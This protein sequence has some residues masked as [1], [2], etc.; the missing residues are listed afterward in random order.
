MREKKNQNQSKNLNAI[1]DY[2]LHNIFKTILF[3]KTTPTFT[4]EG[5]IVCSENSGVEKSYF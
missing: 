5:R 3:H 2:L 1:S 4:W